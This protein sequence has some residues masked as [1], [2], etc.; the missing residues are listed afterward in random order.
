MSQKAPDKSKDVVKSSQLPYMTSYETECECMLCPG[1]QPSH[2]IACVS[3]RTI[4]GIDS[5]L[6]TYTRISTGPLAMNRVGR[7]R[8]ED[9]VRIR[10][11]MRMMM[12]MR[13]RMGKG[14]G[15]GMGMRIGFWNGSGE[16]D[17]GAWEK[18]TNAPTLQKG[19]PKYKVLP[20]CDSA[21]CRVAPGSRN[22]L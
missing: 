1:P 21:N 6:R 9:G 16:E 8:K 20:R 22:A 14:T 18:Q 3:T 5:S 12:R 13:L 15:A 2:G 17:E 7:L 19:T 10:M 4:R 11:R